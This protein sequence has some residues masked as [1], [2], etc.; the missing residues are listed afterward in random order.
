MGLDTRLQILD[1]G[2]NLFQLKFNTEFDMMCILRG[3]PWTFNN[4]LLMLKR[5]YKGMTTGN[6][7]WEHASLWVQIWDAPFDMVSPIVTSKVGSRLG[8]VEEVEKRRRYWWFFR[9]QWAENL[10]CCRFKDCQWILK[11]Q[12]RKSE[13][14]GGGWPRTL[15]WLS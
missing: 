13:E 6:V 9:N 1:V 7:K 4:Q 11:K 14:T 12:T 8:V 2:P 10:G 5:W 15:R 3:G